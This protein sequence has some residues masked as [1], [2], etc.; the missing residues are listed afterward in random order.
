MQ[1]NL[2]IRLLSN[3]VIIYLLFAFAWWSVLLYQKN[4]DTFEAKAALL[5]TQ[6][7]PKGGEQV[8]QFEQST[9]YL[10]LKDH[11]R[12]QEWMILGEGLFF[13]ISLMIGMWLINRAYYKEMMAA[14]QQKNFILSITHE[15]KSPIATIRL[16]L[17]TFIK[18]KLAE[19]TIRNLSAN[20]LKETE[21]L[22]TLVN[23]LL[24]SARL[25]T[26]YQPNLELIRLPELIREILSN[27]PHNKVSFECSQP[28]LELA[29]DKTGITSILTNLIENGIKYAPDNSPLSISLKQIAQ[30]AEIAVTDQG[31]GIPDREKKHIFSKFY[32]IGNEDTRKSKGTGLGLYIVAEIVRAHHGEIKV[33]DNQPRGTK[34][35]VSLPL[36]Q[37][38]NQVPH[39]IKHPTH[40]AHTTS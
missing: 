32:R 15:L 7:Y 27:Y 28:A 14:Q 5:Q 39:N 40:A 35:V 20:G 17:D 9:P 3:V 13:V 11:H 10:L 34:F 33:V 36:R 16:V 1:T 4:K 18:R 30:Q 38:N 25:E 29:A 8:F 12:R 2:K 22:L 26:A 19:D 6:L 23:D 21:R 24:L 37:N 31:F